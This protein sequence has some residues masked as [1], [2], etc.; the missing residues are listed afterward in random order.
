MSILSMCSDSQ[1]GLIRQ[2][3]VMVLLKI[4]AKKT[5]NLFEIINF[6]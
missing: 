4:R 1:Y 5:Y 3:N 6:I 2:D